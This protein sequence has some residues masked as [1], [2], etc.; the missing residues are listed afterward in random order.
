MEAVRILEIRWN[1]SV[2]N[3]RTQN[4]PKPDYE[5]ALDIAVQALREKA[6]QKN[7]GEISD[8]YH[9][10]NELYHHRA[11]L[12]SVVCASYPEL[13]WKSKQHSDGSMYDGMF[14]VGIDTPAGQASYHYDVDPYWDMFEVR[15]FDRA[16]VWDGYTPYE[17]INRIASLRGISNNASSESE[18]NP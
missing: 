5:Y 6:T 9:T 17:S 8:G 12:F 14:I 7:L 13:A 16:P 11:I 3:Y 1:A 18:A 15:K 4:A 2:G 10:F